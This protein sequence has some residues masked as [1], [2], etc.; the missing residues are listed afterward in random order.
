MICGAGH[1][2]PVAREGL[3]FVIPLVIASAI[4]WWHDYLWASFVTLL[5]SIA[6]ALFFRNPER[7]PPAGEHLILSPADGRVVEVVHD[8]RSERLDLSPLTRVS[9]FMSI[10][11]THV[12]RWPISGTVTSISHVPGRFLDARES[13][14]SIV[15]EHNSLVVQGDPAPIEVIQIAG[16]IARRIACWVTPGDVVRRGERFGLI[17]FG[18]R[19]D[20][21][22]PREAHPTVSIGDKVQAGVT[23]IAEYPDQKAAS[24]SA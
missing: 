21:Y 3:V 5:L 16:K 23:V 22:L 14:A 17:R 4:C 13:D 20:V 8:A 2:E 10:F 7:I 24:S 11:N 19:L 12:N 9:I 1:Y 15:N 6:V 18:S